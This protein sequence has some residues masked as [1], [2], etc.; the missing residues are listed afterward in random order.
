MDYL[1]PIILAI[2]CGGIL[3]AERGYAG[4]PAGLRTYILV[5]LAATVFT[6][7]ALKAGALRTASYDP[8]RFISQL[9]V[10]IGFIGGGIIVYQHKEKQLHGI[11][12]ATS[13][14]IATAI[15]MAIGVELYA[16]ALIVTGIAFI[17]LALLPVVEE[18]IEKN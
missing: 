13:L 16:L 4:K 15:G 10:G 17:I 14:W 7:I 3:G 8:G 2:I 5:T 12:T 9:I 1:L 6:L 11:T 18:K